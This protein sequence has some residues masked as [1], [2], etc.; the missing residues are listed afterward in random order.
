MRERKSILGLTVDAWGA[1]DLDDAIWA[2]RL[3]DGSIAVTVSISDVASLVPK[4][5]GDDVGAAARGMNLY[6]G[7][8]SAI[9]G[10]HI[11]A[12]LASLTPRVARPVIVHRLVLSR[13]GEELSGEVFRGTLKSLAAL[14]YSSFD[15]I[16]AT[17]G[18]RLRPMCEAALEAA[19]AL[20]LARLARVGLPDWDAAFDR[21]GRIKESLAPGMV[22]QSVVTE[23][24]VAANDLA[25][26]K[27]VAA[28]APMIFRNQG[29][30]PGG[31]G[32]RF[33]V[34][35]HGN[36]ALGL[37]NYGQFSSPMRRYPDLVN[38]RIQCAVIDGEEPPYSL[39]E[40][41]RICAEANR[42]AQRADA[43]AKARSAAERGSALEGDAQASIPLGAMD[44]VAFRQYLRRK[45]GLDW[46]VL[47]ELG[48][49]LDGG[50]VTHTDVAWLL[51]GRDSPA[52]DRM[53][54]GLLTR[55]AA[56]PGEIDRIWRIGRDDHSLPPFEALGA[57]RGREWVAVARAGRFASEAS[58]VDPVRVRDAALVRLA[59]AALL[60]PDPPMPSPGT[61]ILRFADTRARARLEDLC[62]LM[63]WDPPEF[64]VE[65]LPADYRHKAY[66]GCVSVL[67]DTFHYRSPVSLASNRQSVEM[68][69]AEF[70]MAALQPYADDA[71]RTESRLYGVD[72]GALVHDEGRQGS[73]VAV[74]NFCR[75]YAARPRWIWE[76]ESPS[77][78]RF[79]CALELSGGG[80]TAR[81]NGLAATRRVAMAEAAARMVE[82]LT[83]RAPS[84]EISPEGTEPDAQPAPSMAF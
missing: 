34:V 51:F 37:E 16:L 31:P 67:T 40:N 8:R 54:H 77:L 23:L 56:S 32:G 70:A 27:V 71:L 10:E 5:S 38:Q 75:R 50:Y 11:G 55:I 28:G 43:A 64:E 62:S 30:R 73:V 66:R 25:T 36:L 84:A 46:R 45:G 24:M 29:P 41:S 22:G 58:G 20:W 39:A 14:N 76:Q 3:P 42:A 2:D 44:A 48:R 61:P 65:D 78:N 52:D 13:D 12:R 4:E 18:A 33:E 6:D 7:N 63:G 68:S 83:G 15:D 21:R 47:R 35:S 69:V 53:R 9:F 74:E 80:N 79:R 26:R 17:P 60:L 81:T 72:M 19:R 49:R 82:L 1:R 59:A 57:R